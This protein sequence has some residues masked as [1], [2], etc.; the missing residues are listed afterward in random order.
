MKSWANQIF[1]TPHRP[2]AIS[3]QIIIDHTTIVEYGG[4][5]IIISCHCVN[6]IQKQEKPEH[7]VSRVLDLS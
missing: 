6:P 3:E 7:A 4:T 2:E 5:V 1:S